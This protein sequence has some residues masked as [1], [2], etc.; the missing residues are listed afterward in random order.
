MKRIR[1]GFTILAVIGALTAIVFTVISGADYR[2][3][4]DQ[5]LQPGYTPIWIWVGARVGMSIF[6]LGVVAL[7]VSG[8]VALVQRRS[9]NTTLRNPTGHSSKP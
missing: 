9:R 6:A 7:A 8:V 3:Q 2:V 4:E 5:G 1:V